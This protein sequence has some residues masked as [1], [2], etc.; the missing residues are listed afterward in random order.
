MENG[1]NITDHNLKKRLPASGFESNLDRAEA[2]EF[3][4]LAVKSVTSYDV[5]EFPF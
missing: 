4:W 3:L 1:K 2:N 5:M